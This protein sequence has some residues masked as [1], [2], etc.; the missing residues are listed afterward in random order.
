MSLESN[1]DPTWSTWSE[2]VNVILHR[3]Y[4]I[5]TARIAL[6]VGT[7]LFVINHYEE[8][9][10]GSVA[11]STWVKSVATCI[12]PFSVA[13]WGILTARRRKNSLD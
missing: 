7:I 5:R 4:L 8:L 9:I 1:N 11:P 6:I 13:N 10:A 3:P 12:V 2:A